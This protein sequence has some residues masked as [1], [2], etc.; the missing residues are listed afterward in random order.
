MN[1]MLTF[2][3]ALQAGTWQGLELVA[4]RNPEELGFLSRAVRETATA[5]Q[6]SGSPLY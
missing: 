4:E 1:S 5:A 6:R 2:Y 3:L